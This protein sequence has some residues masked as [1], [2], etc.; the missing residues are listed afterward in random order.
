MS[1]TITYDKALLARIADSFNLRKPNRDALA[2]VIE[3]LE[4]QH[5]PG[6]YIVDL[7]TGVG[8]TFLMTALIDYL[9][10]QGVRDVLVI[11]P[12]K[13]VQDK[14]VANF[15]EA[16]P[17]HVGGADAA[18]VVVTPTTYLAQKAEIMDP[19]RL[20][21]L[22]FNIHQLLDS[23]NDAVIG[24]RKLQEA[25][26]ASLY[27]HL[28]GL[29]NLIVIAD[30]H[31]TYHGRAR[32]FSA[33]MRELEAA[34]I[35]GLTATPDPADRDKL[36]F[37]YTLGEAIADG[38][39]K[40]PVI[41]YRP[42][43]TTDER[44]QLL[45]AIDV[46]HV[47]EAAYELESTRRG[48]VVRPCL[49]VV[50]SDIDHAISIASQLAGDDM[51][52]DRAAV[53]TIT[54][55]S[56]D[57]D[58]RL[59]ADVEQPDSPTRAIVS[60]NKLKE[61]WDVRNIAVLVA[62]RR[63]AAQSL[64]EQV[65]GRG[66]RLPFG[67]RTGVA[68][69]DTLDIIAHDSY[70]QLLAQKDLLAKRTM[71]DQA[72]PEVDEQGFAPAP[73]L[74]FGDEEDWGL[75]QGWDG[76]ALEA[77]AEGDGS[78]AVPFVTD[79]SGR[80]IIAAEAVEQRRAEQPP[81][82]FQVPADERIIFPR[83]RPN[84]EPTPFEL[85]QISKSAIHAA[86][87]RHRASS[88][89]EELARDGIEVHRAG[90]SVTV[91]IRSEE[92]LQVSHKDIADRATV[93]SDLR[94]A[95]MRGTTELPQTVETSRAVDRIVDL[96]LEVAGD[97]SD[98]TQQWL[99]RA[100]HGIAALIRDSMAQHKHSATWSVQ[101][102]RIAV[103]S[104]TVT[105]T[106]RERRAHV[107]GE[108]PARYE[109]VRDWYKH[110]LPVAA[111]D[112]ISTEWRIATI[113]DKSP[114]ISRWLRLEPADDVSIQGG[115]GYVR[116]FPDFVAIDDE[117]VHWLIEGKDDERA[118][119]ESVRAKRESAAEWARRASDST[120]FDEEWRYMFVTEAALGV[121]GESWSRLKGAADIG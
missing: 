79:E 42:G 77:P 8:K 23:R 16:S 75:E 63:L 114:R 119:T 105:V 54:S 102:E 51:L 38:Y 27:E 115:P 20:K 70:R 36:I 110:L 22:V 66:L 2:K 100:V 76:G 14:T 9:A 65:M 39:V 62:L 71:R 90:A 106:G 58:L 33:A 29:E 112:A 21:V 95:V 50:A 5:G 56:S 45:D 43:G 61:G 12:G 120:L 6:E 97:E 35:I 31:H 74:L 60:V 13:V 7:A 3:T 103:P 84:P 108:P 24:T 78:G 64:T 25:L 98:W 92:G 82:T 37:E 68:M 47:K 83:P 89:L 30:E 55:E 52:G 1:I 26:G 101:L 10:E 48:K 109:P 17:K 67:E 73:E 81:V 34:A 41:V 57:E 18:P 19:S 116:Y 80:T 111:F 113:L 121:A 44:L 117:G 88:E 11:T 59:L 72:P 87:T 104:R 53:L 118:T 32:A 15:D 69:V 96:F 94:R 46:L 93:V 28:Q 4:T 85:V 107:Q 91:G 99:S 49:F 86:G 40:R